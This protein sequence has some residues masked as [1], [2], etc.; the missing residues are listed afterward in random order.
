MK[1]LFA[2]PPGGSWKN[3]EPD[4]KSHHVTYEIHHAREFP[5][6]TQGPERWVRE[7]DYDRAKDLL[8]LWWSER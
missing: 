7:E 6:G 1:Y 8:W 5:D 4:L 2:L 3:T